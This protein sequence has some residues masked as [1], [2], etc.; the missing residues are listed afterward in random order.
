MT[1]IGQDL[2]VKKTFRLWKTN[3]DI[4]DIK[5]SSVT[6]AREKKGGMVVTPK[7]GNPIPGVV[8]MTEVQPPTIIESKSRNLGEDWK[9]E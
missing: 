3:G 1:M 6:F 7:G 2:R 5:A 8:A 9:E 4:V